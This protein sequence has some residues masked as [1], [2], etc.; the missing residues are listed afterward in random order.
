MQR[1]AKDL[2]TLD[3]DGT[4]G[5]SS[6]ILEER[7]LLTA[8]LAA[9]SL[10][11]SGRL[12]LRVRGESMLPTLWPGDVVEI[13]RCSPDE[14]RQGEIVLAVRDGRF[15]LHRFAARSADGFLLLGDSM[16]APDP[17]FSGAALIGLLVGYQR[18]LNLLRWVTG[19]LLCYCGPARRLALELHARRRRNQNLIDAIAMADDGPD[20]APARGQECPRYT[21]PSQT[22]S[23]LPRAGA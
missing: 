19:R 5:D 17:E 14:V 2:L 23:E 20:L 8:E 10:R 18:P 13:A 9:E 12:R 21:I 3:L 1:I 7:A 15:F 11:V 6:A 4:P 22:I 16:P